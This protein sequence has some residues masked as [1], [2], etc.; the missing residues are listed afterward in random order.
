M[1]WTVPAYLTKVEP[2]CSGEAC[3]G[4]RN[5]RV[6]HGEELV[7]GSRCR[8]EW[9]GGASAQTCPWQGAAVLCR[10]DSLRNRPGGVRLQADY[11]GSQAG[12]ELQH[13]A[14]G[15]FAP[16]H[17]PATLVDTVN[18]KPTLRRVQPDRY[19]CHCKPPQNTVA[20]PS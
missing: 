14:T 1:R 13:L 3:N 6:G 4:N 11:A 17:H 18:L 7:S 10:P 2:R 8:R 5:D 19:D 12:K 20:Q 16:K 15:K 9:P